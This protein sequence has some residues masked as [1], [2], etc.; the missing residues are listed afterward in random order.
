MEKLPEKRAEQ[1]PNN[2]RF[3]DGYVTNYVIYQLSRYWRNMQAIDDWSGREDS[4]LR[5]LVPNQD[6]GDE[7]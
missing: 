5:P 7:E 3:E 2:A 1:R 6:S 4:N